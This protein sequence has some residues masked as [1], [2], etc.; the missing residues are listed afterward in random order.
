MEGAR[1]AAGNLIEN[2]NVGERLGDAGEAIAE[3]AGDIDA[4][5]LAERA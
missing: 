5:E 4:G 1:D 3:R 2:A